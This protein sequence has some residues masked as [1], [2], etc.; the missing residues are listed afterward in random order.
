MYIY[1]YIHT[2]TRHMHT[3]VC[4]TFTLLSRAKCDQI[5]FRKHTLKLTEVDTCVHAYLLTHK[6][7]EKEA[8]LELMNDLSDIRADLRKV[9]SKK[10]RLGS[11]KASEIADIFD[12]LATQVTPDFQKTKQQ[13]ARVEKRKLMRSVESA[14]SGERNEDIV[15]DVFGRRGIKLLPALSKE[16]K[17]AAEKTVEKRAKKTRNTVTQMLK[18]LSEPV[19][20]LESKVAKKKREKLKGKIATAEANRGVFK[21][22]DSEQT[23]LSA[24]QEGD[25]FLRRA[26]ETVAYAAASRELAK[27]RKVGKKAAILPSILGKMDT[28]GAAATTHLHE[29]L[30]SA[31]HALQA[32]RDG[33]AEAERIGD[34]AR[35]V[36]ARGG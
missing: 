22:V 15:A 35:I 29:R 11:E 7:R 13:E 9:R 4:I 6:Q 21:T 10:Q 32:T 16:D 25:A 36:E 2:Y 5:P 20:E 1:I 28:D 31:A 33:D 30:S 19:E 17:R 8:A 12:R 24:V 27:A 3:Y 34:L 26:D 14:A 18:V 23:L